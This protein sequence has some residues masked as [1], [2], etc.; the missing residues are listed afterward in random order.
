MALARWKDLCIDAVDPPRLGRFWAAMTGRQ[1][2]RY[3]DGEV[4]LD[5]ARPEHTIWV[6][7]VPEPHTVKNR[8]HLD[9]RVGDLDAV[10]AAGATVVRPPGE[11]RTWWVLTDPEGGEFCG[12]VGPNRL[13]LPG[14]LFEV[15]V[16]AADPAAHA[17]W[18]SS[19]LGGRV[20]CEQ[21]APW[22][23]IEEIPGLPFE[24][25]VFVPV[26]EP[27]TVKN[28]V[29]WDVTADSVDALVEYGAQVLRRPDDDVRWHVLADPEGNEFC[30][31]TPS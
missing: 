21:P 19:V 22:C 23:W 11:D 6:N 17:H 1:V 4:R 28:R 18:W 14:E 9:V 25:L 31:F 26:P 29:H 27:K 16:D 5:G 2:F 8:V 20:R 10:I 13:P 3:D 30:A 15:I 12:F 7:A 24:S